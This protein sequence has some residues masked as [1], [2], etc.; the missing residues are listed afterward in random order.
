MTRPQRPCIEPSCCALHRNPG[1]RC[2]PHERAH[3][4]AK[5][6]KA[7]YR[8]TREWQ[9]LSQTTRQA[10]P[11]CIDCGSTEDLT[12]DHVTPRSLEA[13]VVTRCRSCNGKKGNR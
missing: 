3:Q 10:M 5:N 1:P 8:R 4:K 11:F 7:G 13:G 9:E 6:Q 12:A 2:G